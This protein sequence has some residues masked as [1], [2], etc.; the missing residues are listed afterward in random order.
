MGSQ[1]SPMTLRR[2]LTR[3]TTKNLQGDGLAPDTEQI[4]ALQEQKETLLQK[5]RDS[6]AQH[7]SEISDQLA[8]PRSHSYSSRGSMHI[9]ASQTT[10]DQLSRKHESLAK[11]GTT[12]A[13]ERNGIAYAAHVEGDAKAR[14]RLDAIKPGDHHAGQRTGVGR[15]RDR[16]SQRAVGCRAGRRKRRLPT[17]NRQQVR[18]KLAVVLSLADT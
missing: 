13:D 16:S 11:R 4:A 10:V 6:N 2:R 9:E 14:K 7:I 8:A 17:P 18:E 3:S 1:R 12:L 15:G 5:A